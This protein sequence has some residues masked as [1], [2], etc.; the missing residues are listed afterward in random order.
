MDMYKPHKLGFLFTAYSNK[1]N[2]IYKIT[3]Y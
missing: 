1:I 3:L 2:F